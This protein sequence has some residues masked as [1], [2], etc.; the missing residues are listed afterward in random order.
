M[1]L[2]PLGALAVGV[3]KFEAIFE[4][5]DAELPT[6]TVLLLSASDLLTQRWYVGFPI[7]AAF[8]GFLLAWSLTRPSRASI[9]MGLLLIGGSMAAMALIVMAIFLPLSHLTNSMQR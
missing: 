8:F 2:G 5:F 9:A 6:L 4:S 1:W 7:L 3:P